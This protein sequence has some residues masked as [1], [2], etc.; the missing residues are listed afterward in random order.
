MDKT[1]ERL[2]QE[3]LHPARRTEKIWLGPDD[4]DPG[5][6]M[7]H[8][9]SRMLDN[10]VRLTPADLDELAGLL[11]ADRAQSL[12]AARRAEL[13]PDC[14]DDGLVEAIDRVLLLLED[15]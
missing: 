1:D 11:A 8:F 10:I 9:Q 14:E 3:A 6:R 13:A 4:S 12:L 15:R 2:L 5:S 7:L